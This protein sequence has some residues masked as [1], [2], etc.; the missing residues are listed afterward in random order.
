MFYI[1]LHSHAYKKG[2]FVFGNNLKSE[3]QIDN[4]L[5]PKLISL[6]SLNFDFKQCEF[7][8]ELF[9]AVDD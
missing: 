2:C 4:L 6:N 5:F 7:S 1:D 3:K 9:N 8:S